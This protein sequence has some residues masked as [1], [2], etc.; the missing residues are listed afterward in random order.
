[1]AFDLTAVLR[2]KDDNFTRNMR[3]AQRMSELMGNTMKRTERVSEA[4]NASQR[5]VNSGLNEFTTR[6]RKVSRSMQSMASNLNPLRSGFLGLASAIGGAVAAKKIFD[7]TV[8]EAAKFENSQ[9][10][11]RAMFDD[12]KAADEYTKMLERF[13]VDSPVLNS[14]EMF[15]NSKSFISKTKDIKLL[16]KMWDLT[17]RLV[18]IDPL[19]GVEGAVYALNEFFGS[20]LIS[21]KD[22]FELDT[23]PLKEFVKA[24]I[25]KKLE[26][27]DKYFTKM[28]ATQKL[29]NAM[30]NTTI[31]LWNRVSEQF[32]LVLR[33]MGKPSLEVLNGFFTQLI[34]RMESGE[35]NRFA[36]IGGKMI[37]SIL[38][39]LTNG[40]TAIYEWFN[41]ITNS[42]EFKKQT[43]LYGKVS[44]II[45]DIYNRFMNWL[46]SEGM[47]KIQAITKTLVGTLAKAIENNS[48]QIATAA[49][50]V[51]LKIGSAIVK[52]ISDAISNNPLAKA[53]LGAVAGGAIGSVIPGIGTGFG[54]VVGAGA[55]LGKHY[56]DK[57]VDKYYGLF[58]RKK[59]KKYN[60][61]INYVPYDGMPAILHRGEKVLPRGEANEYRRNKERVGNGVT[62]NIANMQVRQESDIKKIAHELAKL[63][64]REGA[65]VVGV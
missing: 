62:I 41:T 36:E 40:V 6:A 23:K 3:R 8:W 14:Q 5:R 57:L 55:A 12:R 42:E 50:S 4:F 10:V 18:A 1:M 7:S 37:K 29:V 33:E 27:L 63:I 35:L 2:L 56:A 28:G 26:A 22:R 31:G 60:G 64:E 45:E 59:P 58:S 19:Q 11:I 30:G 25:E 43:T 47:T 32:Q 24:P 52:G 38:T 13:A 49:L 39:G 44:F 15:E 34:Q 20:D 16:E 53:V 61:G 51:G 48:G 17:E 54:A 9:V 65:L 46:N 21:L